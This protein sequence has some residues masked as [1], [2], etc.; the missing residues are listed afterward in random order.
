M[1]HGYVICCTDPTSTTYIFL[2]MSSIDAALA[3]LASLES[4]DQVN[5][6][7]TARKFGCDRS[8]LSKRYRGVTAP[9]ETQYQN[10]RNLNDQQE[11]FLVKYIDRLCTCAL[12]SSRQMIR[13]FV[14]EICGKDVGKEWVSRFLKRHYV[15][16]VNHLINAIL[17]IFF[18]F[19]LSMIDSAIVSLD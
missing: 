4:G 16:L 1:G 13:N 11:K 15:D 14:S 8:T 7:K 9:R 6:A 19:S 2:N 5:I 18:F 10:Q 12:S 3:F 17:W